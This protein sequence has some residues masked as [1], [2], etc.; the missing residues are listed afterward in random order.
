MLLITTED[1]IVELTAKLRH[2]DYRDYKISAIYIERELAD[3]KDN[4][5]ETDIPIIYGKNSLL[6]YVRQNVVD[7][8]FIDVCNSKEQLT[9][10]SDIFLQMGIV[11]HI[12][13]GYLPDNLPNAFIEKMGEA[14]A[15][16]ASINTATGWQLSI[17]RITDINWCD[18]RTYDY[19]YSVYFCCAS[20]LKLHLQALCFLNKSVLEKTE[21]YFI[22]TNSALC[23]WMQKNV[24]K[25]LCKKNEMQGTHVQDGK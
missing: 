23:I 7:D 4:I 6:E 11:V 9:E 3:A 13:M 18:S 2:K 19:C 24:K 10:L 17:K 12:G 20:Y 22:Y 21:E 15:I 16:T 1:R 14:D 25:I 8:V 5:I